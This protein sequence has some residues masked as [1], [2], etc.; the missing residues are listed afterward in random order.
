MDSNVRAWLSQDT[1]PPL[2]TYLVQQESCNFNLSS[3]E[4]SLGVQTS[5]TFV[6]KELL[7]KTLIKKH[8]NYS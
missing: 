5:V 8:M 1:A 2:V 4:L 3:H 6:A 7:N